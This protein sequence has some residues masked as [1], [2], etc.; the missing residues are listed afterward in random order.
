M[1]R[2]HFAR[3]GKRAGVRSTQDAATGRFLRYVGGEDAE[4]VYVRGE[5]SVHSDRGVSPV[6]LADGFTMPLFAALAHEYAALL[7]PGGKPGFDVGL[8]ADPEGFFGYRLTGIWAHDDDPRTDHLI[9]LTAAAATKALLE[10]PEALHCSFD[11]CKAIA[12]SG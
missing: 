10:K 9:A 12:E 3:A 1:L 7:D 2:A 11:R 5:L 4:A 6:W 8:E